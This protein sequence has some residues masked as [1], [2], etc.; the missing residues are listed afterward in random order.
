[1]NKAKDILYGMRAYMRMLMTRSKLESIYHEYKEYVYIMPYTDKTTGTH[2][3]FIFVPTTRNPIHSHY[4]RYKFNGI[5]ELIRH[6]FHGR[7]LLC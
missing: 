7:T 6:V 4:K 3:S 1:M 5:L 2:I